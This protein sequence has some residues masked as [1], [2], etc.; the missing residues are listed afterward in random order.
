MLFYIGSGILVVLG[1]Y[2]LLE[3]KKAYDNGEILSFYVSIAIWVLDIVHLLLV[4]L[5]SFYNIW[6][7]PFNR[8][9]ALIG[10][11]VIFGVG[12]IVMIAG[13]VEFRS[14]RRI[15]V[16]DTSKAYHYRNISIQ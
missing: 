2:C 8:M 9:V 12:F 15:S 10:G 1:I 7:L 3:I 5:A 6:L 14:L 13:M 16:L 11:W 4:I